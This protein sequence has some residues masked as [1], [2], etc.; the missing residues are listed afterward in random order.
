MDMPILSGENVLTLLRMYEARP[1][2]PVIGMTGHRD[3]A[4]KLRETNDPR[5]VAVLDKPFDLSQLMEALE[6]AT[7]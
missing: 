7:L 4:R 3:R 2:P 5:V 6:A 1:W